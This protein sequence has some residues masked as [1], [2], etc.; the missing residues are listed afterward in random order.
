MNQQQNGPRPDGKEGDQAA[1]LFSQARVLHRM[2]E[3]LPTGMTLSA[4]DWER[5]HRCILLLLVLH[6]PGVPLFGWLAGAPPAHCLAAGLLLA[7]TIVPAAW[8]AVSRQ[9]RAG[10]A[11]VGLIVAGAQIVHF[12]GGLIEMHFYFFVMVAVVAWYQD[13]VPFLVALGAI[14]TH[15]GLGGALAPSSV[16]NHPSALAEPWTWALIHG[17]FILAEST[18]ILVLWRVNESAVSKTRAVIDTALDAVIGMDDQGCIIDWNRTAEAIFGWTAEEVLGRRLSDTIIPQQYR[19][20]HERGFRHFLATGI[21]PA[22]GRRIEIAA[23]H[24]NGVQFPVELAVSPLKTGGTFVFYAFIA[25]ITER[26]QAEQALQQAKEAAEAANRAKSQFLANMSHEIRTPMNGVL[27]MAELLQRSPLPNRE[28]RYVETIHQSGKGL[29]AIINDILD[30]SKIEAGRLELEALSFDLRGAVRASVQ[31]FA[32][33]AKAKGLRLTCDIHP[34]IPS[35]LRNDPGRLR[36]ILTNLIG[37][38]IKFT[39]QGHVAV[40]V[41]L[42]EQPLL[43]PAPHQDGLS[44]CFAV[45]DSGIGLTADQRGRLFQ[46]FTQ[47][48]ASTT[49]Q[50]GG[51]GLGLAICKQLAQLMGGMIGVDSEPGRGSTFWFTARFGLPA[52][53]P[54]TPSPAHAE[55]QNPAGQ[56][57]AEPADRTLPLKGTVLLADDNLVNQH[58]AQAMIES[59]GCQVD[60]VTNG[61]EAL[62]ALLHRSYDL[63]LMDCQMPEMDGLEATRK[64]RER[65]A[66]EALDVKREAHEEDDAPASRLTP[67]ASRLTSQRMPIIAIT[68][69]VGESNRADCLA[70]GMDDVLPKPVTRDE[71]RTMLA[72]YLPPIPA[73]PL[74]GQAG[75]AGMMHRRQNGA[76]HLRLNLQALDQLRAIQ[77]GNHPDL[78]QRVISLYVADSPGLLAAMRDALRQGNASALE[79]AAHSLKSSSA[80]LGATGLSER[81]KKLEAM[82]HGQSLTQA[83]ALLAQVEADLADTHQALN[84]YLAQQPSEHPAGIR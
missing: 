76:P 59:C 68:A 81:C 48:D 54:S 47:A 20:A 36:Q 67:D 21:G 46:A 73:N 80:A 30:F 58:V 12:S 28:R 17:G 37:N 8:P 25:D 84:D 34:A 38:A 70:A 71:V 31:L 75:P 52:D 1:G 57:A 51:T 45:S 43:T 39:G 53:A 61:R 14:V 65:E 24:R 77:P 2:R 29:L 83:E 11:T 41:T 15:H 4:R 63:V 16:Y 62:E 26:K 9:V 27:G 69:H 6:L 10:S 82:A 79:R 42:D 55:A 32:E 22:M 66:R 40:R 13:W 50:Y 19:D 35:I 33:Q 60:L 44:L 5:R 7:A 23:L 78:I 56:P 49:R 18:A 72:R 3:I 64:I 74:P